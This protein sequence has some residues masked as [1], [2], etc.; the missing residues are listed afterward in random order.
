MEELMINETEAR[1]NTHE[2]VCAERYNR[3]SGA[4]ASGTKRMQKIEYILYAIIAATLFG[5]GAVLKLL[6]KLL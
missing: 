2:A 4:L 5:P 3:I 1:L 6:E